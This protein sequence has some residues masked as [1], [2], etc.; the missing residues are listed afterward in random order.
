MQHQENAGPLSQETYQQ[1][2]YRWQWMVLWIHLHNSERY[3]MV[4][5]RAIKENNRADWGGNA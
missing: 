5:L 2:V 3:E 1:T 4:V